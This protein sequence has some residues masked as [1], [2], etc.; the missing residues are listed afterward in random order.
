MCPR[1]REG[2]I[3]AMMSRDKREGVLY[4]ANI[5][6]CIAEERPR[7]GRHPPE[8]LAHPPHGRLVT[9]AVGACDMQ[10]PLARRGDASRQPEQR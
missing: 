2:C 4:T 3:G 8:Q 10:A 7:A 1:G 6:A 9:S 5:P